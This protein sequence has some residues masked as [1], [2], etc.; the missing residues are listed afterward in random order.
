[1]MSHAEGQQR[2]LIR[3][4]ECLP[5]SGHLSSLDQDLLMLKATS[6]ATMNCLNDCFHILQLQHASHQKGSLPSGKL[7]LKGR[8]EH[9]SSKHGNSNCILCNSA[10]ENLNQGKTNRKP[11]SLLVFIVILMSSLVAQMVKHL[12]T[13]RETQVRSLCREDPLEKEMATH[14]STLAWKIPWT[15]AENTVHYFEKVS[16]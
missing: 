13:M 9:C 11:A 15:K 6:M 14:S 8:T 10:P 3:G 12:P 4:I 7:L 5:A 16:P 1:M 2:D